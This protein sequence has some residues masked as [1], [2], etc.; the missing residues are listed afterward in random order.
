[1]IVQSHW[2]WQDL[3]FQS[4]RDRASPPWGGGVNEKG[5]EQRATVNDLFFFFFF[6]FQ[7]S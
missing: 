4:V 6:P 3:E 7:L 1:M 2:I 5:E